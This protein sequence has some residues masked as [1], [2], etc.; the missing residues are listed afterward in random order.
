MLKFSKKHSKS[1]QK[2]PRVLLRKNT[3]IFGHKVKRRHLL[4]SRSFCREDNEPTNNDSS[5]KV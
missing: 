4:R 1:A 3:I 5:R 2:N